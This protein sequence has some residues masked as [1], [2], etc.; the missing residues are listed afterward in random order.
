MLEHQ[1][2]RDNEIAGLGGLIQHLEGCD[3]PGAPEL[4][5]LMKAFARH[6]LGR[7]VFDNT[8]PPLEL[9]NRVIVFRTHLL[10]LP[11][12]EELNL[13]HLFTQLG[14]E[15][16]F[17]RA[18]FALLTA[19]AKT[20]CFADRDELAGF[21]VDEAHAV[22]IS[23]EGVAEIKDFVRDGRKHR[24]CVLL[25]S[26]DP[27]EDF[28]SETMRGLIPYRVLMRHTDKTLARNGLRWLDL[29][30]EDESLVELVTKDTSPELGSGVP[31]FRRGECLFRD[32]AGNVGRVKILPRTQGPQPSRP[33][34][35]PQGHRGMSKELTRRQRWVRRLRRTFIVAAVLF[36]I[37]G[38]L[39]A[40]GDSGS[41]QLGQTPPSMAWIQLSDDKGVDAWQYELAIKTDFWEPGKAVSAM[42][43]DFLWGVYRGIVLIAIWFLDWVISFDW[44]NLLV[45]PLLTIGEAL[46]NV[47]DQLGLVPVF[48]LITGF[49]AALHLLRGRYATSIYEVAIAGIVIALAGGLLANPV[50]MVAGPGGWI[51]QTRD[52]TMELVGA[53]DG[54][55]ATDQNSVTSALLKTFVRQPAQ[56]VAFGKVLDGTGCEA[57]FDEAV[58]SGPHGYDSTIRD[59]IRDCDEDAFNYADNPS[60]GM[61]VAVGTLLPSSIIIIA[62]AVI[63][64]G[65][66]M[67][68]MVS[69]AVASLKGL[70]NLVTAVLPGGARRPLMQSAADIVIGLTI[71]VF[72]MFFLMVFLLVVQS[73]FTGAEGDP[74]Q[75]FMITNILLI[76]GIV[77]F[78]GYRKRLKAAAGRLADFLAKRPGAP[79]RDLSRAGG[80]WVALRSGSA[81][82]RHCVVPAPGRVW[83]KASPPPEPPRPLSLPAT[84]PW[85]PGWRSTMERRP[86]PSA[87]HEKPSTGRSARFSQE[88]GSHRPATAKFP[89]G[90][91]LAGHHA[92]HPT[93]LELRA[94][95][96]AAPH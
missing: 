72:S 65:F 30:P 51:Y 60:G 70:V 26:H 4:A 59:A 41:G 14:I 29:D 52:A 75:A 8:V 39:Y 25:G 13:E 36:G 84:L 42:L 76:I 61:V 93:H 92:A 54:Q 28:P 57:E 90:S 45:D 32:S 89:Q 40:V 24:A 79:C 19:L 22:T 74:M 73:L 86:S 46:S 43:T 78:V 68:A 23:N 53:M 47:I 15:K 85:Q 3:L 31:E 1:Y 49:V 62:M 38:V 35:G 80:T 81:R 20:R 67:L 34:R 96:T 94:A 48:L 18:L 77:M 88:P 58:L 95:S 9:D 17:G 21:V 55:A 7:V 5:R 71:F 44:L 56:I 2:L 27:D 16:I 91:G 33:N 37:T 11:T 63:I 82:T 64:G 69:V 83:S 12:R 66:V 10:Q 6:D 87:A 50:Q